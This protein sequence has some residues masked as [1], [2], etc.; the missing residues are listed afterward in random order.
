MKI[1]KPYN[2]IGDEKL[3]GKAEELAKQVYK[4]GIANTD[5]GTLFDQVESEDIN[6]A[7]LQDLDDITVGDKEGFVVDNDVDSQEISIEFSDGEIES[8]SYTEL[9]K[10]INKGSRPS[11]QLGSYTPMGSSRSKGEYLMV[12]K[13]GDKHEGKIGRNVSVGSFDSTY[14]HVILDFAEYGVPNKKYDKTEVTNEG[15]DAYGLPNPPDDAILEDGGALDKEFKFDKNFVIYVPSTT[16]VGSKINPTEMDVRVNSVGEFVADKFGGFT[17]TETDGGY[18]ATDG[19]IIEEDIVKVSV[20]AKDFDW[21]KHED[22]VVTKVKEW[23]KK[24]GQEAIGFEYEGKLYYI[25]EEG[26]FM[27]GGEIEESLPYTATFKEGGEVMFDHDHYGYSARVPYKGS[28][29]LVE[30]GRDWNAPFRDVIVSDGMIVIYGGTAEAIYMKML[31]EKPSSPPKYDKGGKLDDKHSKYKNLSNKNVEMF[32][33]FGY[34]EE[35]IKEVND[36]QGRGSQ[37]ANTPVNPMF[38]T[39]AEGGQ[40]P[41]VSPS[42]LKEYGEDFITSGKVVDRGWAKFKVEDGIFMMKEGDNDWEKLRRVNYADGGKILTQNDIRYGMI[43]PSKK[44]PN[45]ADK[46]IGFTDKAVKVQSVSPSENNMGSKFGYGMKPYTYRWDGTGY[47]RQNQYLHSDGIYRIEAYAE[48]GGIKKL[49]YSPIKETEDYYEMNSILNSF[50]N[51]HDLFLESEEVGG[52][53]PIN[54]NGERQMNK[55]EG[56]VVKKGKK[57]VFMIPTYAEGGGI[58]KD[59]DYE[60]FNDWWMN[61]G[62]FSKTE[63]IYGKQASLNADKIDPKN[64]MDNVYSDELEKLGMENNL[65]LKDSTYAEG[66]KMFSAKQYARLI[67]AE[68]SLDGIDKTADVKT[69]IGEITGVNGSPTGYGKLIEVNDTFSTFISTPS[70]YYEEY[71]KKGEWNDGRKIPQSM[72]D[73]WE[74]ANKRVGEKHTLPTYIA[75]NAFFFE[76]GGSTYA[77][78]GEA[79]KPYEVI[80]NVIYKNGD[81]EE[82]NLDILASNKKEAREKAFYRLSYGHRIRVGKNVKKIDLEINQIDLFAEGGEI[83]RKIKNDYSDAYKNL[84]VDV[85]IDGNIINVYANA[86]RNDEENDGKGAEFLEEINDDYFGGK[87]K[88]E[89]WSDERMLLT[90]TPTY[91]DGGEVE[92]IEIAEDGSNVPPMLMEIFSKFNEDEDPYKEMEKLKAKA[93]EI[94]YDFNYGLDG[95]PT[96]FCEIPKKSWGGGIAIGTAVGGYVGYKIGRAR[97]QKK[98]FETEKKIGKKINKALSKGKKKS[99]EAAENTKQWLQS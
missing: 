36:R 31:K 54:V 25:D 60:K 45:Q 17:K 15:F 53:Y 67:D 27:D 35:K 90:S 51:E 65:H 28:S 77:E 58:G 95:T 3:R 2:Y 1:N 50:Y 69:K 78:G 59:F 57:Y 55:D 80:A 79:E 63:N 26:K 30:M 71:W 4:E 82:I 5:F 84:E 99:G 97:T 49:N 24:W 47:K 83:D 38:N 16:N 29:Y 8:Y 70:P 92:M 44:Y 73:D 94:G 98:G 88:I 33:D 34:S 18:K 19:D 6:L 72:L 81:N 14:P 22:E 64:E 32:R 74:K 76:Q 12:T 9:N 91:A 62:G 7:K 20:F 96:E 37:F 85:M 40:L 93:N 61:K 13:K 10:L 66:G 86:N 41:T 68:R 48:G 87:L 56:Y 21:D 11:A 39:Y 75:W 43:I 89:Q 23:A 46:V 52:I 42:R